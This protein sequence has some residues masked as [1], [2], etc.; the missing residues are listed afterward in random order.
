MSTDK[1][2]ARIAA[3]VIAVCVAWL[4]WDQVG[5]TKPVCHSTSEDAPITDCDYHDGGWYKK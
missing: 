4:V 2:V 1:I 5:G 3:L